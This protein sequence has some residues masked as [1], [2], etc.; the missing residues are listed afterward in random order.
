MGVKHISSFNSQNNLPRLS[1]ILSKLL[2]LCELQFPPL[3]TGIINCLAPLWYSIKLRAFICI[4]G[5][6]N[7]FSHIRLFVTL[8]T[9]AHQA[10]LSIGFFWQ[11]Y[12]SGLSYPPPADIPNPWIKPSSPTSPALQEILYHWATGEALYM[13]YPLTTDLLFEKRTES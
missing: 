8:W 7:C 6:L 11:E 2:T 10:P 4:V 9:V 1:T 5:V 12:W 3:Q 13:H